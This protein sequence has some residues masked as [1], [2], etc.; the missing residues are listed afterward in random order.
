MDKS[1]PNYALQS[2]IAAYGL[3]LAPGYYTTLRMMVATG[4]KWSFSMFVLLL[5]SVPCSCP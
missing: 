4:G 2:T 3:Y 5:L 1:P